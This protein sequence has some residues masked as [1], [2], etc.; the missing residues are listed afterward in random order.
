MTELLKD[1]PK[2][3]VDEGQR[4]QGQ[5]VCHSDGTP[6]INII[7]IGPMRSELDG[8][9]LAWSPVS[10]VHRSGTIFVKA[11]LEDIERATEACTKDKITG[12]V[13]HDEIIA[14]Q[15]Y[16]NGNGKLR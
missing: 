8:K 15:R 6:L 3:I 2:G 1:L 7:S 10:G 9:K 16:H 4:P 13:H 12:E 11:S 14:P 5:V